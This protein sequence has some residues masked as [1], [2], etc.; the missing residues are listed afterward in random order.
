M[1]NDKNV[2][3]DFAQALARIEE[4]LTDPSAENAFHADG[5]IRAL[6]RKHADSIVQLGNL[7][8]EIRD[9]FSI[10]RDWE[11]DPKADHIDSY[12]LGKLAVAYD[13]LMGNGE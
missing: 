8:A 11:D 10:A 12:E 7:A 9:T 1:S 3:N 6:L 4:L 13:Q 2:K 5:Q